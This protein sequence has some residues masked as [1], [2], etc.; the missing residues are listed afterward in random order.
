MVETGKPPLIHMVPAGLF[1][2]PR[3]IVINFSV[4][5]CYHLSFYVGNEL[6]KSYS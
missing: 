5:F 4:I 2:H 3:D 1:V 6:G